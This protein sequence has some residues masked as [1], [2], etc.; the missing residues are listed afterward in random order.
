LASDYFLIW[1][2]LSLNKDKI[3]KQDWFIVDD[4]NEIDQLRIKI[5]LFLIWYLEEYYNYSTFKDIKL[6]ESHQDYGGQLY[7]DFD[8]L[9]KAEK[10]DN[11]KKES[12][13]SL[14]DY[15]NNKNFW[16]RVFSLNDTDNDSHNYNK[17]KRAGLY[18][19]EW[20]IDE[21]N[22]LREERIEWFYLFINNLRI[23]WLN[24]K[25]KN[26]K[27]FLLYITNLLNSVEMILKKE[28]DSS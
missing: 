27:E 4:L 16:N 28:L 13:L 12:I 15:D 1:K 18:L 7:Y 17:L 19:W 8:L 2:G 25:E 14:F 23:E 9:T 3:D 21:D 5:S 6:T 24:I 22:K 10:K 20:Q 26:E 11:K